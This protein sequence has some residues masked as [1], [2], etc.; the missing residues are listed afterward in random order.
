MMGGE[1]Q[2]LEPKNWLL[3]TFLPPRRPSK[4]KESREDYLSD[5]TSKVNRLA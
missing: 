4:L 1:E 5:F 2:V 3:T